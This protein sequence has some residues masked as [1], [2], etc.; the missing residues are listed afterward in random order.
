MSSTEEPFTLF[1]HVERVIHSN[2]SDVCFHVNVDFQAKL[3]SLALDKIADY[4]NQLGFTIVSNDN[5]EF[6]SIF[7]SLLKEANANNLIGPGGVP[8]KSYLCLS[9][10]IYLLEPELYVESG[11]F[12]GSTLLAAAKSSKVK[13]IIG[14]DPN[15]LNLHEDV[16]NYPTSM[17]LHKS[18]FN[19][20]SFES[21]NLE[22][23]LV[24]FDDHISTAHRII[25]SYD[26]GFKSL[27]FDDSCGL[28]GSCERL[29]PSLPS[30]FFINNIDII[31]DGDYFSWPK[32]NFSQ[33]NLLK[34]KVIKRK[35]AVQCKFT[36]DEQI[37]NICKQAK[38][39]IKSSSRLP[40][41]SDMIVTPRSMRANDTSLHFVT[42]ID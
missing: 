21:T 13:K 4:L 28:M 14:F 19:T 17:E 34:Y 33:L 8:E 40:D 25:E 9:C 29:W 30:L 26:K 32:Y 7:L 5:D 36:F 37:I 20:Y 23:S 3:I 18:D 2:H 35:D 10:L 1:D 11:F 12:K 6:I 24:F 31:E 42:L 27:I 15:H 38:S 39:L 22:N 41:L 16:K